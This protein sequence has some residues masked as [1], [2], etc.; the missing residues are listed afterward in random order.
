MTSDFNWIGRSIGPRGNPIESEWR[1]K[2]K[3][4]KKRDKR[5]RRERKRN[6]RKTEGE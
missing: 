2:K 6:D 3:C 4:K 1:D 5:E